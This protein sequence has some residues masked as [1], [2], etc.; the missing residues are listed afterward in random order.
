MANYEQNI[1]D[2]SLSYSDDGEGH[3]IVLLHGFCGSRGYFNK[4]IPDISENYRVIACDLRGHGHSST[5]KDEYSITSMADDLATLFDVLEIEKVTMIGHSLGGYIALAFAEKYPHM[6]HSYGLLHS[7]ALPDDENGKAGREKGIA[8]I[9]QE[10]MK[11]FI[12]DLVP[13]LFAEE[14]MDSFHA[15]METVRQIGY[16]TP[17]TGAAGALHAMK[18]RP[19][20][21]KV[22]HNEDLPVLLIAGKKDQI[23][24]TEKTFLHRGDHITEVLLE[25]SGHMGM[26]EEPDKVSEALLT[27]IKKNGK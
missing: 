8:R 10:G 16:K 22:L 4:I 14:N 19:D 1:G 12:N 21:Q 23:V 20:R 6:L 25:N 9:E 2:V 24:P 26:L 3:C 15:E 7:T 11:G 5:V 18:N 17:E 13:K 27:F